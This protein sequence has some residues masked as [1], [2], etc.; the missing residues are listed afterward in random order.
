MTGVLKEK[1]IRTDNTEERSCED[2][3]KRRQSFTDQ[4]EASEET[5]PANSLTS[6]F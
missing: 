6:D 3:G 2:T 4:G 5:N 1:E